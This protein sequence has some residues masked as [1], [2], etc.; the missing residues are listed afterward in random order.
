[1]KK[2][3]VLIPAF[4]LAFQISKAQTEK[5][6]Q[7]IGIDLQFTHQKTS[8]DRTLPGFDSHFAGRAEHGRDE[9]LAGV[10][11]DRPGLSD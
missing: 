11:R 9:I 1:M 8:Q 3:L 5:G 2:I 10:G 4:L 7:T 6:S